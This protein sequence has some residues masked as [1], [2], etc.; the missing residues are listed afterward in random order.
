MS[1]WALL[2]THVEYY[3]VI[4]MSTRMRTLSALFTSGVRAKALRRLIL[5]GDQEIGERSLAHEEKLPVGAMRRE[6]DRLGGAGLV[7]TRLSR[8][9]RFHRANTA[10]PYYPELKAFFLK[11]S[12]F[13]GKF[14]KLE[15]AKARIKV[16][17]I[18]GSV[19][20]GEEDEKSDVDLAIVG[21]L[22]HRE[23]LDVLQ[24]AMDLAGRELNT[25][26]YNL[27]E[28]RAKALERGG[29]VER[30][31]K[32]PKIFLIGSEHELAAILEGETARQG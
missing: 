10:H 30:I 26:S 17:F 18:F 21:N 16:A 13:E 15:E 11:A 9:R 5:A 4:R 20:R 32:S 8:R 24:P 29:F 6:L 12:F 28:F 19:A 7:K 3:M 14:R 1:T 25:V 22:P 23:A 31:V 27:D 2:R